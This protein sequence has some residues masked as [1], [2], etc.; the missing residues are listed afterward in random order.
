MSTIKFAL[1]LLL[2]FQLNG[3]GNPGDTYPPDSATSTVEA[4]ATDRVRPLATS[5]NSSDPRSMTLDVLLDWA[6]SGYQ[7]FFPSHQVN[8]QSAP[9]VYRFYPETQTY[10][11]SDGTSI[12][13]LGPL[14][15]GGLLNVGRISDFYCQVFAADCTGTQLIGKTWGVGVQV[16]R[17]QNG[18]ISSFRTVSDSSGNITIAILLRAS[19]GERRI[20]VFRGARVA[21]NL[22]WDKGQYVEGA[23]E[24]GQ[25][26]VAESTFELTSSRSGNLLIHWITKRRCAASI[27]SN[28]GSLCRNV[29]TARSLNGGQTWEIP[30]LVAELG[31][32]ADPIAKI[33]DRGDSVLIF[34]GSTARTATQYEQETVAMAWRDR[35]A[36]RYSIDSNLGFAVGAQFRAFVTEPVI[37][38]HGNFSI[39]GATNISNAS[40]VAVRG[41]ATL[42]NLRRQILFENGGSVSFST[43]LY[44]N[45]SGDA[46]VFF[47]S[48]AN[49]NA[50]QSAHL[51]RTENSFT[52]AN[53]QHSGPAIYSVILLESG[54]VLASAECSEQKIWRPATR[55][56]SDRR[57]LNQLACGSFHVFPTRS[58]TGKQLAINENGGWAA[59]DAVFDTTV[60]TAGYDMIFGWRD[61]ILGRIP[62]SITMPMYDYTIA[63]NGMGVYVTAT[64]YLEFP[65]ASNED[66]KRG[67]D[68]VLWSFPFR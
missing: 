58:Q 29:M 5:G 14:S 1:L 36:P 41:N 6:E 26:S 64:D 61:S 24:D 46:V 39:L 12:F 31:G 16:A 11:G 35:R 32:D 67:A 37:D 23:A 9:Y 47:R 4:H 2:G 68:I 63:D 52:V 65:T 25:P 44:G 8:Q 15:N 13:V 45:D 18:Q 56:W 55:N 51:L 42:G 19:T 50:N 43:P 60:P 40:L 3:C 27:G 17:F 57:T 54:D 59:Y 38:A 10:L 33:N 48:S 30:V 66:G 49:G 34:P 22:V 7:N 28:F 21:G 53:W 62:V 20:Q